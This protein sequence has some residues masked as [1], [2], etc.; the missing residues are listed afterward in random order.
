MVAGRKT[1]VKAMWSAADLEEQHR[2]S[3]KPSRDNKVDESSMFPPTPLARSSHTAS[4]VGR[5]VVVI[6]G[7]CAHAAVHILDVGTL[8]AR[9]CCAACVYV[10]VLEDGETLTLPPHCR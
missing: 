4:L 3:G 1:A 7:A 10:R 5:H 6:G 8:L 2:G 9:A